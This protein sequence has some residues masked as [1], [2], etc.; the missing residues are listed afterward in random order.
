M[1]QPKDMM[2]FNPHLKHLSLE[3]IDLTLFIHQKLK[4]NK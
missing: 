2:Q 4:Q 3:I 1:I